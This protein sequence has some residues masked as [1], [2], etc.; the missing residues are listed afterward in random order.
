MSVSGRWGV[1]SSGAWL[2]GKSGCGKARHVSVVAILLVF[3]VL[4]LRYEAG[5]ADGWLGGDADN[6]TPGGGLASQAPNKIFQGPNPGNSRGAVGGIANTRHNL[7]MSY[8]TGQLVMDKYRNDYYEICVYCHTPHGA[9]STAAAPLWNR[10]VTSREYTLYQDKNAGNEPSALNA[11]FTQPGPNSLTCLSCHDGVTAI[12]SIINMP[13]QLSGEFRAGYSQG[14][15][16]A[17][18]NAFLD[19]WSGNALGTGGPGDFA[20]GGH[21]GFRDSPTNCLACHDSVGPTAT[22]A[23]PDFTNFVIGTNLTDDHP[24]G[25][26]YPTKF[27]SSVDFNEPNVK[28]G[29]IA[30]FDI[31]GNSHADPDEIRLY[32][33]GDGYEVECGSCHDPH[34]VRIRNSAS[35]DPA[36]S[37]NLVPSF[38]RVGALTVPESNTDPTGKLTRANVG[39]NLCLTCHVK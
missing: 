35:V 39:S 1:F 37:N 23:K 24:I 36:D 15:E 13:T 4:M 25:V 22:P 29:R 19:E 9:N 20:D 21:A 11:T 12:D 32:D 14:Q 28:T 33:T 27:D 31:N 17:V 38:L 6:P 34:G 7:T 18:G 2:T 8:S 3:P 5:H 30:F 10:T 16:T 26:T